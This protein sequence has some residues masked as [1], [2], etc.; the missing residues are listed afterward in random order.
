M[1]LIQLTS[2]GAALI[3]VPSG[4]QG[5]GG[6]ITAVHAGSGLTGGGVTGA[7]T[8]TV[9][10]LPTSQITSGL[11]AVARLGTGAASGSTF[12]RGDRTWA[13]PSSASFDLSR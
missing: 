2:G 7:V 9:G 1:K 6:D 4:G 10:N 11:F 5:G 13:T 8:L 3:D 12:L